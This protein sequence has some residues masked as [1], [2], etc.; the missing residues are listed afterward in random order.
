MKNVIRVLLAALL[1]V[2]GPVMGIAA[3][4][5]PAPQATSQ[6]KPAEIQSFYHLVVRLQEVDAGGRV[7]NTR[8]YSTA[9]CVP[10]I[11]SVEIR[12]DVKLTLRTTDKGEQ[13]ANGRVSIHAVDARV[14]GSYL[15]LNLGANIE[16]IAT[17]GENPVV[18]QNQWE[19]RVSVPIGKPTVVFSS[20]NLDDKG[21][22]QL[23][24]TATPLD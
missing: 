23:E 21:K 15:R 22:I 11:N 13:F 19:G 2:A 18:R 14:A 16:S 20:D 4:A 1:T 24:L 12:T 3:D 8:S 17:P 10:S 6:S 9:I 5:Q 7:T